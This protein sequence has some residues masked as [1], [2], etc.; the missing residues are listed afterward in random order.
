MSSSNT[1]NNTSNNK[2]RAHLDISEDESE[3]ITKSCLTRDKDF[4]M[5]HRGSLH[6]APEPLPRK[7]KRSLPR[8]WRHQPDAG[9]FDYCGTVIKRRKFTD[10]EKNAL[11]SGV[12]K[13]GVG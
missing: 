8:D 6:E 4:L 10:A 11:A 2:K 3:E 12:R 7:N 1:S 13:F 5:S 9:I